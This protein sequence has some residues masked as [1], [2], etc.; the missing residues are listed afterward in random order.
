MILL[1]CPG[2]PQWAV[3]ITRLIQLIFYHHH[4][5]IISSYMI[6][7]SYHHII[8]ASYH[9]IVTVWFWLTG[10]HN[11]PDSTESWCR[12]L[13]LIIFIAKPFLSS[14]PAL[15]QILQEFPPT[16]KN[17]PMISPKFLQ[18]LGNKYGSFLWPLHWWDW[19]RGHHHTP[20]CPLRPVLL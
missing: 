14:L 11:Q 9:Y 15:L 19:S 20:F 5:V 1:L 17:P 7:L 2:S 12:H 8:T 13:D 4:I 18:I 10:H 3:A 6:I 16:S